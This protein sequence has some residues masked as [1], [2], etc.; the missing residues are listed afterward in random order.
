MPTKSEYLAYRWGLANSE[1]KAI[2][3]K[4]REDDRSFFIELQQGCR[5]DNFFLF[6]LLDSTLWPGLVKLDSIILNRGDESLDTICSV[7]SSL[8][9]QDAVRAFYSMQQTSTR[10]AVM[11]GLP[12]ERKEAIANKITE[13]EISRWESIS[14]NPSDE[15]EFM[16]TNKFLD[17]LKD[18]AKL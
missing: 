15:N 6:D 3:Y 18:S 7:L 2:L 14:A 1:E 8:A 12:L 17:R 13:C 11:E 16:V 9:D 4:S 10:I 5:K